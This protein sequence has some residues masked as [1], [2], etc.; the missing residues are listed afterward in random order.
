MPWVDRASE[1]PL[2][3][4]Q[5]DGLASERDAP[6]EAEGVRIGMLPGQP[7]GEGR[8][9]AVAEVGGSDAADGDSGTPAAAQNEDARAWLN[10]ARDDGAWRDATVH[11]MREGEHSYTPEETAL[12]ARGMAL[13]G[14]FATGKGKVRS[15]RRSKTVELAETK[16]DEKSGLL[17]GHV[18]AEVRTSPEQVVAYLMHIDSKYIRSTLN[19]EL[20]VRQ[21]VLEV[22]SPHHTVVFTEKKTAPFHNRTFLN[23]LLWQKV[24][25]T[26]LTYVWVTVPIED[27][28]KI[29][30]EDEAHAIRAEAT[31][32]VRA[33][34]TAAGMT[35]IEYACSLDL[36]GHFPSWLTD[37]LAIPSLMRLPYDLQTYFTHV[38]PPSSCTA[39]DSTHLGH[40]IVDTAEAAKKP[41]RVSAVRTFVER[42]AILR[43]SGVVSLDALLTASLGESGHDVLPKAVATTDP[44]ALTVAEATT[45]GRGF[46]AIIRISATPS[47]AVDE[48]LRKY[49]AVNVAVQQHGW[50]RPMLETI[51]KRRL[52]TQTLGLKL[53][54]GIGAVFSIGDM[55]SDAVQ[56]VA[57]FL[58]GQ[59]LRAF[60]LL[61]MIVMNLAVQA[62]TVVHQTAHL[63]WRAIWWELSVVFSLLK[64]AIDAVRVASGVEQVEGAL[65]DPFV[66][67]MICKGTEMTFESIPGG[68]AQAVFLL[69]GGDWTTSAVVSVCLSCIS[70]AFTVTTIAFDLDTNKGRRS[71]NPEF[72]GY[73][74]DTS[75]NHFTV[76]ML[77]FVYHSA[78]TLG[79]TLSMAVLAQ[80]NSLWL[81][82]YL[83]ADHC[84]LILYKL[85]RGDLVYWI[86]GFSVSLSVL[87]R[88][89]VKVITDF[90]GYARAHPALSFCPLTGRS[91][92]QYAN[93]TRFSLQHGGRSLA[94]ALISATR[95]QNE[96]LLCGR[97]VHLRHPLELGGMYFFVNA[98]KSVASWFAA[99]A[100]YSRYFVAGTTGIGLVVGMNASE[101]NSSGFLNST[102]AN[103]TGANTT[104]TIPGLSKARMQVTHPPPPQVPSC[105]LARSATC[106][107][108]RRSGR[109]LRCG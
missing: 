23:V 25:D 100:L 101:A 46:D 75:A 18:E 3:S 43:E 6:P 53:R 83:L 42:T 8:E 93:N 76:F 30:P 105:T 91:L 16:H 49:A 99:A 37:R 65:F 44:G 32:C 61:A 14:T 78:L 52:A 77:L 12:I 54:L 51:A 94:T 60:A 2:D 9:L 17:I 33:T 85:A 15:M 79:N 13:L 57:L 64:P 71:R 35:R 70:T 89:I 81:V 36:K 103:F 7:G 59:S 69:D 4:E 87:A 22:M 29:S 63:G 96:I 104:G 39:A 31:R 72:Y 102:G 106:R 41:E 95:N 26:P 62:L 21:E 28:A 5:P 48:L 82:A 40:L 11:E 97:C 45:I 50:A 107:S 88:F 84:G 27:H 58:A 34:Q 38:M 109:W 67:M 66:E 19:P 86:P 92:C 10:D 108:L 98:L 80:T 20:N 1:R 47:D 74:A 55:A 73:I 24:S 90:T 68:L 56:I